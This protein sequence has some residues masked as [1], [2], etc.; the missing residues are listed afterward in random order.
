MNE[1][2]D[3]LVDELLREVLIVCY[4]SVIFLSLGLG[5]SFNTNVKFKVKGKTEKWHSLQREFFVR[6]SFNSYEI[7]HTFKEKIR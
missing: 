2:N 7:I 6:F 3:K 4:F 5:L 1:T